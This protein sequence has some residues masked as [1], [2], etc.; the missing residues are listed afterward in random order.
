VKVTI[1][2]G[3]EGAVKVKLDYDMMTHAQK[4][5]FISGPNVQVRITLQ[6][7]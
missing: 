7:M 2:G 3:L 4:I 6:Q 1:N 5:I